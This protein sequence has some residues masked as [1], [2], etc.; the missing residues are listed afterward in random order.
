MENDA[1]FLLLF[2]FIIIMHDPFIYSSFIIKTLSDDAGNIADPD[3]DSAAADPDPAAASS[4][5]WN[6]LS[7]ERLMRVLLILHHQQGSEAAGG[8]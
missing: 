2:F 6:S 7:C 8:Y 4:M 1:K 5:T 3:S